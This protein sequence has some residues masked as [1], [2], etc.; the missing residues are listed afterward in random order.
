MGMLKRGASD[1]QERSI[2][3]H[4]F[5]DDEV[6]LITEE[7]EE[8]EF[9]DAASESLLQEDS[10]DDGLALPPTDE[11]MEGGHLKGNEHKKAQELER[12]AAYKKADAKVAAAKAAVKK[13][14]HRIAERK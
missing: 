6:S 9:V 7:S 8:S 11:M 5:D 12:V 4:G 14:L 3:D 2:N 1:Q 13:D 10:G